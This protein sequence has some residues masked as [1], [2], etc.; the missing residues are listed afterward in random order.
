MKS[1][2]DILNS[3]EISIS[4][5]YQSS[6][7]IKS[8]PKCA[9]LLRVC[10]AVFCVLLVICAGCK[11][12]T[13]KVRREKVVLQ[14]NDG[15]DNKISTG[16]HV[17]IM[18][19]NYRP[20]IV[21]V[22]ILPNEPNARSTLG[23]NVRATDPENDPI[24][25]EYLWEINGNLQEDYMNV[26][27]ENSKFSN[28]DNIR[29]MV[30]PK[31][32]S[33]S[34]KSVWTQYVV[35]QDK[36]QP[37]VITSMYVSPSPA[38]KTDTLKIA[39]ETLDLDNDVASLS[40]VWERNGVEIYGE[41]GS[42]LLRSDLSRGDSIVVKVT[43]S[44]SYGTG[45]TIISKPI[46][47]SNSPPVAHAPKGNAAIHGKFYRAKIEASDPDGDLIQYRLT[48]GPAG[49]KIDPYSG[50]IEWKLS[51]NGNSGRHKVAVKITDEDGQYAQV[52]YNLNLAFSE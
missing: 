33:G 23:V 20:E 46:V 42:E 13:P 11:S 50:D 26:F 27:L 17:K 8:P 38:Y 14:N 4:P 18:P 24:E 34:G 51:K 10:T 25:Y 15:P 19:K 29:A 5:K 7:Y 1:K 37:P 9:M 12:K 52:E 35:I 45:K 16:N 40:Y 22:R 47:I 2:Y 32:K 30:T 31:D 21:S 48:D 44:D 41:E 3:I 36:N 43:P 39:V 28:G 6:R 49:M